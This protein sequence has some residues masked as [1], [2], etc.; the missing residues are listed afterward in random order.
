MACRDEMR[1]MCLSVFNLESLYL[2]NR[3]DPLMGCRRPAQ[4]IVQYVRLSRRDFRLL[5]YSVSN[6]N[7]NMVSALFWN[8]SPIQWPALG[9]R[10]NVILSPIG[11][12]KVL[13]NDKGARL[14]S[15]PRTKTGCLSLF[16]PNV[17]LKNAESLATV[18]VAKYSYPERRNPALDISRV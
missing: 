13:A 16:D 15:P 8:N 4:G 14:A 9:M 7:K 10:S 3:I 11:P 6:S 5:G 12:H 18:A 17:E 2:L 1:Y